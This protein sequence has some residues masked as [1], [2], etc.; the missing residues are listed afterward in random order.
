MNLWQ[1]Q[2]I[3]AR[4]SSKTL[5]ESLYDKYI[6]GC[7]HLH[8]AFAPEHHILKITFRFSTNIAAFLR[9]IGQPETN[10]DVFK[11]SVSQLIDRVFR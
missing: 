7:H 3:L 5:V 1:G 10:I 8:Q 6:S 2:G 11:D 4:P 9:Y